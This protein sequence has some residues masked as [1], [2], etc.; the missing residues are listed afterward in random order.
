MDRF[1]AF[2]MTELYP[3]N[4]PYPPFIKGGN[5]LDIFLFNNIPLLRKRGEGV[6]FRFLSLRMT[7]KKYFILLLQ[8]CSDGSEFF[9]PLFGN[10]ILVQIHQ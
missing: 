10:K 2:A 3:T 6:R 8:P 7:S 9:H 4:P 1:T 5:I